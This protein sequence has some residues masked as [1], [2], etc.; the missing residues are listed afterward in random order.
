MISRIGLVYFFSMLAEVSKFLAACRFGNK[1]EKR[2]YFQCNSVYMPL[3]Q[4]CMP[5]KSY[6]F[7]WHR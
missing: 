7:Q 4:K 1:S 3:Y 6:Y 5:D 2:T